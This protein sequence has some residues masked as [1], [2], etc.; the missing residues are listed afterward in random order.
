MSGGLEASPFL[1]QN[2]SSPGDISDTGAQLTA[3][4][5]PDDPAKARPKTKWSAPVLE[6]AAADEDIEA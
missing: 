1:L 6:T 4:D 3:N 2:L 5:R